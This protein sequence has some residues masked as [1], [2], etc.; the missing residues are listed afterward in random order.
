MFF[1]RYEDNK[2]YEAEVLEVTKDGKYTIVSH[3]DDILWVLS[4]SGELS[5]SL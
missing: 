2:W 5:V 4:G 1:G 3:R